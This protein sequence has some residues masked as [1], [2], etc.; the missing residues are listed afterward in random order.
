MKSPRFPCPS[1]PG[2]RTLILALAAGGLLGLAACGNDKT[3]APGPAFD[4]APLLANCADG[5]ILA[6]YQDLAGRAAGLQTAVTALHDRPDSTRLAAARDAWR[7]AR[8]PWE[9][10]EG[11]L[12]G[13]VETEGIDP[14]IDSWPVNVTDLNAVLGSSADLTPEFVQGLQGTLKGF[15]TIEYLLWGPSGNLAAAG[16]TPRALEYLTAV[17]ANLAAS[18]R[19]LADAWSP[20]GGNFAAQ[21]AE[22]G[23]AGGV[24]SSP[25]AA[26]QDLIGGMAGIAD[27]VA[28]SKINDPFSTRDLTLEESRFSANSLDDFADN[29]RSIQHVYLGAYGENTGPGVSAFVAAFDPDL[30]AT[31]RTQIQA[32]IDGLGAV[33][34]S[35]SM[36]VMN[37]RDA[38]AAAQA[39]IRTLQ[40]TIETRV[41]P[42]LDRL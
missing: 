2:G 3:T 42:L 32:A 31:V 4:A 24:Y 35:F 39:R 30:D 34:E 28:N 7:D 9:A 5:V 6:T 11:F 1:A 20:A 18:T 40:Q 27:E 25:R 23:E 15:H 16:L 21:L 26:L 19:R 14:G 22:A 29:I 33:P 13:P 17:T 10:S 38:V 37:D 8:R 41:A 36:A 12:F